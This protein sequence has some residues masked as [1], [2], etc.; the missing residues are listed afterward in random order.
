MNKDVQLLK[1]LA[2]RDSEVAKKAQQK[3]AESVGPVIKEIIDNASEEDAREV[4]AEVLSFA[5][6]KN[7]QIT[8]SNDASVHPRHC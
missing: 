7:I 2:S 3:F 8:F 4:W 5:A 6:S 1:D